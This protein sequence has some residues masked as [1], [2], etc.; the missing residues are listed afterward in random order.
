M[1]SALDYLERALK[2]LQAHGDQ[3]EIAIILNNLGSLA[4]DQGKLEDA[5]RYYQMSLTAKE[6][7][8]DDRSTALTSANL[9]DIISR[10]GRFSEA[11]R[12]LKEA[13]KLAE[14]YRDNFL[15]AFFRINQG[16][17][18]LRAQDWPA[19]IASYREALDYAAPVNA[20]RFRVLATYG[21]GRALCGSG[22]R[23]GGIDRLRECQRLAS[24]MGDEIAFQDA[25]NELMKETARTKNKPSPFGLTQR[26]LQVMELLA[27]GKLNKEIARLSGIKET[28][29]K[30]H[31]ANIFNRLE[32]H[33]RFEAARKWAEFHE[34]SERISHSPAASSR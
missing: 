33:N 20:G 8:G 14:P 1:G 31:V 28:T 15:R 16:D 32:V 22:E 27:L 4:A 17:N 6:N 5:E 12:M 34:Q 3:H 21:L 7:L 30:R 26:E 24:E 29:V 19:S 2:N 10:R 25:G 23:A 13:M 11:Q 9:A 18:F